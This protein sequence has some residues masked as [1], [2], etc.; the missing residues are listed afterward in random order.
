MVA[1]GALS[2]DLTQPASVPSSRPSGLARFPEHLYRTPEDYARIVDACMTYSLAPDLIVMTQADNEIDRLRLN[3]PNPNYHIPDGGGT[4]AFAPPE[5][6]AL[7]PK[8]PMDGLHRA[9]WY[10]SLIFMH[11]RQTPAGRELLAMVSWPH[12]SGRYGLRV[13]VGELNRNDPRKRREVTSLRCRA[14]R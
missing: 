11:G 3:P 14:R 1:D 7:N 2:S 12:T 8:S 6:E 5:L 4:T 13:T 10:G 9:R